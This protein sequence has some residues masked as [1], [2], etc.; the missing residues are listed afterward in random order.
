MTKRKK[1]AL[2]L[3]LLE[4]ATDSVAKIKE[5]PTARNSIS[6]AS[7]ALS[8]VLSNAVMDCTWD[9]SSLEDWSYDDHD[10]VFTFDVLSVFRMGDKI[11]S[12]PVRMFGRFTFDPKGDLLK[13]LDRVSAEIEKYSNNLLFMQRAYHA[14]L[15]AGDA[16]ALD[17]DA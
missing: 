15:K 14:A 9:A 4:F 5:W 2:T 16:E 13:E 8:K 12:K 6:Y 7:V 3:K 17:I 10:Q 11:S 1:R